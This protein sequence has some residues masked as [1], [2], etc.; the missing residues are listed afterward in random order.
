MNIVTISIIVSCLII[1]MISAILGIGIYI[2]RR[3]RWKKHYHSPMSS[4]CA[5]Q[6]PMSL[7][8]ISDYDNVT[9]SAFHANVQLSSSDDN[10]SSPMTTSDECSYEPKIVYLGGEQQLTAIFA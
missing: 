3:Q 6:H 5:K 1:F 4:I 8:A 2:L 10:D 7:P 9:Y